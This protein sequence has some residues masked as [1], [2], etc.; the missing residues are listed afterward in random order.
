MS[1]YFCALLLRHR[2]SD[3]ELGQ[4]VFEQV[5]APTTAGPVPSRPSPIPLAQPDTAVRHDHREADPVS[6]QT[7]KSPRLRTE[8]QT[9]HQASQA[10]EHRTQSEHK[11]TQGR[12][13]MRDA[14]RRQ[15][16]DG[17]L[18]HKCELEDAPFAD[19]AISRPGSEPPEEQAPPHAP[20]ISV[21][22]RWLAAARI[23]RKKAAQPLR[24][25]SETHIRYRIERVR[26]AYETQQRLA[27]ETPRP[28]PASAITDRTVD[29]APGT[30][31]V[32]ETS[33]V[34]GVEAVSASKPLL[35]RERVSYAE[36][37]PTTPPVSGR[38][39]APNVERGPDAASLPR[40]EIARPVVPTSPRGMETHYQIATDRE[41]SPLFDRPA[42]SPG[43]PRLPEDRL[44]QAG[45]SQTVER[46]IFRQV[47]TTTIRDAEPTPLFAAPARAS[48]SHAPSGIEETA[49]SAAD[50]VEVTIDRLEIRVAAPAAERPVRPS[51]R[52]GLDDYLTRRHR[53][54][55]S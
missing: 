37:V 44:L 7:T 26:R 18:M 39:H 51:R 35:A 55:A 9:R 46:T 50:R 42:P 52:V 2:Q 4:E 27:D 41:L 3:P 33:P 24:P 10:I 43:E 32:R 47:T 19:A 17:S 48:A 8:P 54:G 25:V 6:F 45:P 1:D 15:H 34:F 21:T 40:L 36:R 16:V 23:M 38:E 31:H 53:D 5:L 30:D 13:A 14:R 29:R 20:T 12:D 11:T 49:P 22:T 28:H